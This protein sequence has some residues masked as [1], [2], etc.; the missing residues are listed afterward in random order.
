MSNNSPKRC[1]RTRE[2]STNSNNTHK[3][4]QTNQLI[5]TLPIKDNREDLVSRHPWK[6]SKFTISVPGVAPDLTTHTNGLDKA[7]FYSVIGSRV[8]ATTRM[9]RRTN[10][11]CYASSHWG[12][13]AQHTEIA[14]L[15][16][17]LQTHFISRSF[18][19]IPRMHR[20][21]MIGTGWC[22]KRSLNALFAFGNP[23]WPLK[24]STLSFARVLLGIP[25][26][27]L[28]QGKAIFK[29]NSLLSFARAIVLWQM[30]ALQQ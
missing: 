29:S 13:T 30:K 17:A 28:L 6:G 4:S 11:P 25:S 20:I 12:V 21:L 19:F 9:Q 5:F 16:M 26:R 15:K 7:F 22:R 1:G 2:C 8:V 3:P 23:R 24:R 10:M 14:R 27:G 18:S